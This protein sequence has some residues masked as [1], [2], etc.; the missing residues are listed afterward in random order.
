MMRGN[1]K[2]NPGLRQSM[3]EPLFAQMH[4]AKA[5]FMRDHGKFFGL[6]RF[7]YGKG[8][9]KG[10]GKAKSFGHGNHSRHPSS[11]ARST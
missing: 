1:G 10:H 11:S 4:Q 8:H 7:P 3:S 5:E 6:T 9:G 2:D